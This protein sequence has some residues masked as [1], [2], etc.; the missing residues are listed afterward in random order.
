[1]RQAAGPRVRALAQARAVRL[2]VGVVGAAA[3]L[4]GVALADERARILAPTT[5]FSQAERWEILQGGTATNRK[6]LDREAFSQPSASLDFERR[7]DFFV[8]NGLF[9]RLW[10]SSPSSTMRDM[11]SSSIDSCIATDSNS[12]LVTRVIV[13]ASVLLLVSFR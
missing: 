10:V 1:M 11:P 5:D 9:K 7:G 8:G 12:G 6:R 13:I 2:A 4:A 3:A